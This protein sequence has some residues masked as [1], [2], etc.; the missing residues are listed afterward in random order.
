MLQHLDNSFSRH[1]YR[2]ETTGEPLKIHTS[3]TCKSLLDKIGGYQM[4][5]VKS[6]PAQLR[7]RFRASEDLVRA[8]RVVAMR[9]T[10]V[11]V[12]ASQLK[13]TSPLRPSEFDRDRGRTTA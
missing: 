12:T 1:T 2:M 3:E 8:V 6:L 10:A 4:E 7:E 5:E 9:V 11:R 13:L